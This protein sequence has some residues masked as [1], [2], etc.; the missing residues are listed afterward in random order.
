MEQQAKYRQDEWDAAKEGERQKE[1]IKRAGRTAIRRKALSVPMRWLLKEKLLHGSILDYG[2]GRG[3]DVRRLK[4][5]RKFIVGYDPNHDSMDYW[6]MARYRF[7]T[8]TCNYV[9]NTVDEA[10]GQRIINEL[11]RLLHPQGTAYISVRRDI[12][13]EGM[14]SRNTYQR[15][16]VLDLPIVRETSTYCIYKLEKE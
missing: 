7:D 11:R 14:T 3:D 8:I 15:N 12:K 5:K 13:K 1:A 4:D 16:V 10:T 6:D 2:C 9:L